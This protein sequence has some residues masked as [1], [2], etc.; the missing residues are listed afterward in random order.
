MRARTV[1]AANALTAL[2]A[3]MRARHL[4]ADASTPAYFTVW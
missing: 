1:S 3:L 4:L 2:S